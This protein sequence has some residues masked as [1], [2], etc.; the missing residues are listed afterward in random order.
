MPEEIIPRPKSSRR[1]VIKGITALGISGV[2]SSTVAAS[3]S[4]KWREGN[5]INERLE[6]PGGNEN[7]YMVVEENS[8]LLYYGT[9]MED[10]GN[11]IAHNF[12]FSLVGH[13][14]LGNYDKEKGKSTGNPW[15]PYR[16][17]RLQEGNR[18]VIEN[19]D[20]GQQTEDVNLDLTYPGLIQEYTDD[21]VDWQQVIEEDS[22]SWDEYE[23]EVEDE[24]ESNGGDAAADLMAI[25]ASAALAALSGS[26]GVGAAA[27]LAYWIFDTA[28]GSPRVCGSHRLYDPDGYYYDF[29][30]KGAINIH[31]AEVEIQVPA[32]G[33]RHQAAIKHDLQFDDRDDYGI[34]NGFQYDLALPGEESD[35]DCTRERTYV[36]E[37]Y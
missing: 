37:S 6:Y 24:V 14:F 2:A 18:F 3:H 36:Y 29:C 20:G 35:A 32:D 5:Y 7:D 19:V 33:S 28:G 30:E 4:Y 11:T 16:G 26:T 25:G 15:R 8:E 10:H 21:E 13:S 17:K 31:H 1:N 22:D 12:T 34:D 27:A 9:H 23:T